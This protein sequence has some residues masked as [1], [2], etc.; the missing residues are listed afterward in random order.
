MAAAIALI[1][2]MKSYNLFLDDIRTP[3]Q[4]TWIKLPKVDWTIARSYDQF[5][6][7]IS[8][9]GLPKI[10]A[11]DH[12]LTSALYDLD[13]ATVSRPATPLTGYDCAYWLVNYCIK[14]NLDFPEY[15][16]HSMSHT[17]CQNI[18]SYIRRFLKSKEL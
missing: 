18:D 10:V 13:N 11:F 17:G 15:H 9:K 4:V 6:D 2:P 16:I 7:T 3:Q 12:D 8:V 5:V 1:T 14:H